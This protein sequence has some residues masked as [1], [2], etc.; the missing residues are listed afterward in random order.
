MSLRK[1]DARG[2]DP[3]ACICDNVRERK[4]S[5]LSRIKA[6]INSRILSGIDHKIVRKSAF[7][8]PI[9]ERITH[10][11]VIFF[12]PP[13]CGGTSVAD[14]LHGRFG[15]N[16]MESSERTFA[17]DAI[18]SRQASE[19]LGIALS[20]YREFLLAYALET[21]GIRYVEGHFPFSDRVLQGKQN[22]Y[23]YV[24]VLRDPKE[25]ILSHYY[26]NR[27]KSERDHF[28]IN[29]PLDE[30]LETEQA[31]LAGTIFLRMFCGDVEKAESLH[32]FKNNDDT[33]NFA[34][35][36]AIKNLNR[37]TVASDIKDFQED[38]RSFYSIDLHIDKK[39]RNPE[40]DYSRLKDQPNY[41]QSKIS[42][43]CDPDNRIYQAI[44]KRKHHGRVG[45]S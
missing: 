13:K 29:I 14:A 10:K 43:I 30:W 17:L 5:M 18:G 35:D 24:T 22:S 40:S 37:F 1:V 7:E 11:R 32:E 4:F 27:N 31:R 6:I 20:Q 8:V 2:A 38:F 26:F 21:K 3:R 39:N 25:R 15:N 16:R 45:E 33:L 12:H 23:D 28:P 19:I 34:V 42:E 9:S 41:I 36:C 44:I